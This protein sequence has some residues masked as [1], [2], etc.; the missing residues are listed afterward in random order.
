MYIKSKHTT[1]HRS[2]AA[3]VYLYIH[4]W[5]YLLRSFITCTYSPIAVFC[6]R[7]IRSWPIRQKRI[8]AGETAQHTAYTNDPSGQ[9][10]SPLGCLHLALMY[11]YICMGDIWKHMV[12][13]IWMCG[14]GPFWL[15]HSCC[16]YTYPNTGEGVMWINISRPIKNAFCSWK[17]IVFNENI[18]ILIK[19]SRK[20][21]PQG[22]IDKSAC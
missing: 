9:E 6:G 14:S 16:V 15:S 10:N 21:V 7:T 2:M 5:R 8:G 17:R 3:P 20:S 18:W 12:V 22:P 1:M 4:I 13:Y 19:I 11:R